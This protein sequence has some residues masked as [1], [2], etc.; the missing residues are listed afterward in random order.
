MASW[1]YDKKF[2][3][4]MQ[5]LFGTSPFTVAHDDDLNKK[6]GTRR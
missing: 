4:G 1:N 6:S 5:F 3:M 2:P